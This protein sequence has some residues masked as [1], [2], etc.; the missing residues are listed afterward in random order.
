MEKRREI[1][2]GYGLRMKEI[3]AIGPHGGRGAL[4]KKSKKKRGGFD[5]ID[6][7][8]RGG[9]EKKKNG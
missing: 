4:V 7:K 9:P 1:A 6:C 2:G 5:S 8:K 3:G